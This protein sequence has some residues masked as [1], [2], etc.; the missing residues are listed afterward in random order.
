MNRTI[1]SCLLLSLFAVLPARGGD[2]RPTQPFRDEHAEIREHLEHLDAAVGALAGA[3]PQEQ[4]R[5]MAFVVRFL[6]EHIR[7]HAAWEEEVL[8]PVVDEQAGGAPERFTSTMRHEHVIIGRSID[9]L[10]QEAQAPRPDVVAFA[11]RA[12][13]LLGVISAHFEKEEEILLTLLDRG[14]SADEFR[15]RVMSRSPY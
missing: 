5:K 15:A 12:D 10:R 6:D 9:A 14:M 8:Y 13:R 7:A 3:A 4:A 2:E 1:T 11:R